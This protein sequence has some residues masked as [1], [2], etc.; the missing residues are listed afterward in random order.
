[1]GAAIGTFALAT[2][3]TAA[4]TVAYVVAGDDIPAG[5]PFDG[6]RVRFVELDLPDDA[7]GGLIH[8]ADALV[9]AVA[10]AEIPEGTLITEA[11]VGSTPGGVDAGS[12]REVALQ[13][14]RAGALAGQL[15]AGDL[16]DVLSTSGTGAS[17]RTDVVVRGAT[18]VAI[19]DNG[20][21]IASAG[22][23]V[24][25]LA[26]ADGPDV[27][28]AVHAAE[29]ASATLVRSTHATDE[30]PESYRLPTTPPDAAGNAD[31]TGDDGDGTTGGVIVVDG[32]GA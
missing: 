15:R 6:V 14:D 11:V 28:A 27:L 19:D 32:T 9:G 21:S 20:D 22:N 18:V 4:A 24:V 3:D 29:A 5:T 25:R 13:L 2:R 16:V 31:D 10:T 26:L 8:D 7:A 1:M 23:V 12:V 17:A 30:L